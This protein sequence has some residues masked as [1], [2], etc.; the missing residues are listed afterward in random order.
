MATNISL[1]KTEKDDLNVFFQ[2]QLDKEANY[3][4]AVTS[5]Q[6]IKLLTSGSTQS[7]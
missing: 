5:T 3:L 7:F 1:I 4:A 6:M 2:F